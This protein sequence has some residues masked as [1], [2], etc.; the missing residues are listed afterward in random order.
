MR[1]RSL[2]VATPC[3]KSPPIQH[4]QHP[5][6]RAPLLTPAFGRGDGF[7]G[8]C[9]C[10][11]SRLATAVIRNGLCGWNMPSKPDRLT[12]N[13]IRQTRK[14]RLGLDKASVTPRLRPT[15]S[16]RGARN[17]T[18]TRSVCAPGCQY[19]GR[20]SPAHATATRRPC[21]N[22]TERSARSRAS[23]SS[24][25]TSSVAMPAA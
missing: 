8:L 17:G 16:E 18:S 25:V 4:N 2:K 9:P 6:N 12:S 11:R 23:A 15:P 22:R 24:W 1:C 14:N 13:W 19:A 10:L 21:S 5:T 7:H 3:Q 20:R